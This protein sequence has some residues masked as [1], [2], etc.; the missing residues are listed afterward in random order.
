MS[1]FLVQTSRNFIEAELA[2]KKKQ[3]FYRTPTLPFFFVRYSCRK[4]VKRHR[5]SQHKVPLLEAQ[6]QIKRIKLSE[7]ESELN[8]Y[9]EMKET[10]TTK[11]PAGAKEKRAPPAAGTGGQLS[12]CDMSRKPGIL[13]KMW[14]LSSEL[15]QAR[16][17]IQVLIL[18][19]FAS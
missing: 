16:N 2:K 17:G 12:P 4:N 7:M 6:D 3:R 8:E 14:D 5:M 18:P 11:T 13:K 19:G 9:G 1:I 10:T 15:Y